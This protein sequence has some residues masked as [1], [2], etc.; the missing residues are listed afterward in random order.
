VTEAKSWS[1]IGVR[2]E[3][4]NFNVNCAREDS[5]RSSSRTCQAP[6]LFVTS[7]LIDYCGVECNVEE[8]TVFLRIASCAT[9]E[10]SHNVKNIWH[11]MS[12]IINIV[13]LHNFNQAY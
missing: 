8:G 11:C 3:T 5:M 1:S 2:M 7:D 9:Q 10:K 6:Q 12:C 4:V 13:F